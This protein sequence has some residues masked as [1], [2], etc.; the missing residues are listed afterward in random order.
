MCILE[1]SKAKK[2]MSRVDHQ[3]RQLGAARSCSRSRIALTR[4]EGFGLAQ[5]VANGEN[6]QLHVQDWRIHDHLG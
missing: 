3:G 1:L 2:T 4:N 6:L 5:E